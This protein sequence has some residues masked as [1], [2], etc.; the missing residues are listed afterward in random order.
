M[1]FSMFVILDFHSGVK[2]KKHYLC[3]SLKVVNLGVIPDKSNQVVK[4]IHF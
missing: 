3:G 2:S 4:E 1:G